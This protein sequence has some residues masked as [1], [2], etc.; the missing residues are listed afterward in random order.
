MAG[1]PSELEQPAGIQSLFSGLSA[2]GCGSGAGVDLQR[3]GGGQCL[4]QRHFGESRTGVEGPS[5]GAG[6]GRG[7][8]RGQDAVRGAIQQFLCPVCSQAG[9]IL[10]GR[11]DGSGRAVLGRYNYRDLPGDGAQRGQVR[12]YAG[13]GGPWPGKGGEHR[14]LQPDQW[15]YRRDRGGGLFSVSG[16]RQL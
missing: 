6:R 2:C 14:A 11:A 4:D 16:L 9:F 8:G 5:G 1:E 10:D 13:R 7:C 12:Q 3:D 15:G